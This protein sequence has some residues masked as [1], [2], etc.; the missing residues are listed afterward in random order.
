[1]AGTPTL[2]RQAGMGRVRAAQ[3]LFL[4]ARDPQGASPR[5]QPC[6]RVLSTQHPSSL[7][8]LTCLARPEDSLS[9]EQVIEGLQSGSAAVGRAE[10]E[11]EN[12]ESMNQIPP[13]RRAL[14]W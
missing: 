13:T 3:G 4:G 9:G 11:Q 2:A 12:L 6:H 8:E 1:M 10:R 14:L 5:N 7:A